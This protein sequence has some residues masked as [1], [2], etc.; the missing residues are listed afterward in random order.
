MDVEIKDCTTC[1]YGWEDERLKI[2]FCH[3]YDCKDWELWEVKED[4]DNG[5]S[6]IKSKDKK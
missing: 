3:N 2:P 5:C 4:I 1:K 6:N